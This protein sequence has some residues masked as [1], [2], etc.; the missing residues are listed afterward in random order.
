MT[1]RTANITIR[2]IAREADVSVA[3]VSR[4]LNQNAYVSPSLSERI[5]K[6][7]DRLDYVPQ[8]TAR[9][10]A[11]SKNNTIGL[12]V[13]NMQNNFFAALLA[14]IEQE[15]SKHN[16]NLLVAIGD[17]NQNQRNQFSLGSH[18]TDGL[19]IFADS[20]TDEQIAQLY[21]RQLPM[22][23]IHKTST[24]DLNIPTVTIE[25][26]SATRKLIN[27]LI[28]VHNRT[29][30][31]L[32]R[33][34][35]QQEDSYWREVGFKDALADHDIA[36]DEN[37]TIRGS[38][39]RDIAYNAMKAFLENPTHPEFDAVFCGDDD[40]AIG[41][42]DALKEKNVQIPEEVS[43]V[44]FDDTQIAPF[45][46]PPLTTVM[47][48]TEEV[49]RSAAKQLLCL[50]NGRNPVPVTLHAT[51]IVLRQSCGCSIHENNSQ[52]QG[53]GFYKKVNVLP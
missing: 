46:T 9:Q 25:N 36:F 34:S 12:L 29:Q 6:V 19:L 27:H 45:L 26:K 30:I 21:D 47:A 5:Q 31:L 50:L 18:N 20:L 10:L 48:P 2:D 13:P 32:V 14:G 33:G 23:L 40:A 39:D 43:V 38:F 37:L 11:T 53:G 17:T 16:F 3:T 24:S 8:A 41:I 51:E 28:E 35:E 4:Y 22:V 7:M 15:V 42:Y 49:G 44:G 1:K 52:N